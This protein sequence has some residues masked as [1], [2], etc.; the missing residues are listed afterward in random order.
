MRTSIFLALAAACVLPA[1]NAITNGG[2][3]T[4]RFL[5]GV[6]KVNDDCTGALIGNKCV[7]TAHHCLAKNKGKVMLPAFRDSIVQQTNNTIDIVESFGVEYTAK[8]CYD[9]EIAVLAKN[10][11]QGY[12]VTNTIVDHRVAVAGWGYMSDFTQPKVLQYYQ[13]PVQPRVT[14]QGIVLPVAD[15]VSGIAFRDSGGPLFTCTGKDCS[16]VGVVNGKSSTATTMKNEH[17]FCDVH[18]NRAWITETVK[19]HCM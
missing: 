3:A 19:A 12:N 9:M 10:H 7:L 16:I 2:F 8:H 5:E 15:G 17:L 11:N 18:S 1:A 14:A 13:Y 4:S 6:V